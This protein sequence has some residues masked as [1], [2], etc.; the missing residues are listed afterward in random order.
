MILN[1]EMHLLDPLSPALQKAPTRDG[2]GKALVEAAENDPNVFGLTADV[3]ESVRMNK[4]A[5]RFPNRFIQCGIAEQ[6]MAGVAAGL[7]YAGKT[8][9]MAAYAVF[10]PGR[11][12]DQVKIAICYGNANVKVVASHAGLTVG[13]DGATHQALEDIAMMRA[14][15]NMTIFVPADAVEAAKAVMV[16]ARTKGPFYLRLGREKL[17]VFTTDETPFEPGKGNLLKDGKDLTIIACGTMVYES[18]MA[19]A[20]LEKQDIDAAVVNMHTLSAMDDAL[21]EKLAR[22]TG[23]IVTAEEHQIKGGLGGAVAESACEHYPVP[24]KRIGMKMQWGQSGDGMELLKHYGLYRT[25][26]AAE[27]KKFMEAAKSGK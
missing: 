25:N 27:A 1:P 15:P 22:Q 5:E 19:A 7:A 2:F 6:N 4:F 3:G 26:I 11:N 24:M 18:L 21:I 20:E 16:A 23:C 12:F 17:P 9:F 14:L 10:S 8:A 13:P